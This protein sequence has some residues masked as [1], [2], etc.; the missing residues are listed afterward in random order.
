MVYI[1]NKNMRKESKVTF[2][3]LFCVVTIMSSCV[4]GDLYELYDD[5]LSIE[6]YLLVNK[7]T[8]DYAVSSAQC[9]FCCMAY[10]KY[11]NLEGQSINNIFG[12][13]IE[14]GVTNG[15]SNN[16]SLTSEDI[17]KTC[18][19]GDIA[20]ISTWTG[21]RYTINGNSYITRQYVI[22]ALRLTHAPIIIQIEEHHWVVGTNIDTAACTVYYIDP[23]YINYSGDYVT[24]SIHFYDIDCVI[25]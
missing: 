12:F 24:G 15:V 3:L 20:D 8:K 17:A 7:T 19:Q 18:S 23:K 9:G 22:E 2:G 11:G 21:I 4:Q 6:K 1:K 13:A 5:N 25:Y 14:A 16:N 10:I